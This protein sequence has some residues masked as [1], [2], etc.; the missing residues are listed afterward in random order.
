MSDI[1]KHRMI[2]IGARTVAVALLFALLAVGGRPA[3]ADDALDSRQLVERAHLAFDG[4]I[5]DPNLG[6]NLRALINKARGVLI[7]PQVFRAAFIFGGSG[8]SG[9]P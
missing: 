7:Y 3:V 8:G 4:F 9:S 5:T 1:R 6:E 2:W